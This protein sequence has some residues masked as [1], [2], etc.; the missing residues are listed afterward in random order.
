MRNFFLKQKTQQKDVVNTFEPATIDLVIR[1]HD[2]C[3]EL[4]KQANTVQGE[5]NELTNFINTTMFSGMVAKTI[6]ERDELVQKKQQLLTSYTKML[7]QIIL[8]HEYVK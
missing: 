8:Q 3:L 1:Y 7:N 2:N 4:L 6:D 5:I